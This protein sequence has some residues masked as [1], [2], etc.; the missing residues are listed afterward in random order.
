MPLLCVRHLRAPHRT[1][2]KLEKQFWVAIDRL[3]EKAGHPWEQWALSMLADKPA[4]AGAASWL[5]VQA[6]QQSTQ[7]ATHG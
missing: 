7:G 4:G 5:R 3:A 6:L 1:T 2:I